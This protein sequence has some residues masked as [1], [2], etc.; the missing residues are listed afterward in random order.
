MTTHETLRSCIKSY[1]GG[2]KPPH[3]INRQEVVEKLDEIIEKADLLDQ[4]QELARTKSFCIE[5]P[6]RSDGA[7]DGWDVWLKGLRCVFNKLTFVDAV[8]AAL[9]CPK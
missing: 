9:K 1:F 6:L 4:I 2:E 5:R 8:K 3:Y 7:K